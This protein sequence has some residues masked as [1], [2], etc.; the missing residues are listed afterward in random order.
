MS[1]SSVPTHTAGIVPSIHTSKHLFNDFA[2]DPEYYSSHAA[3]LK[4]LTSAKVENIFII[5]VDLREDIFTVRNSLHYWL[6]FM[7]YQCGSKNLFAIGSHL[8][9]LTEDIAVKKI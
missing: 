5:V 9:L 8:D 3:I 7:D 1:E 2:G 4:N 6:S